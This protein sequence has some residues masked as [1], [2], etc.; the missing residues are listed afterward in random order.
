ML[1]T[2][3]EYFEKYP[4]PRCAACA[5]EFKQWGTSVSTP[6]FT[7]REDDARTLLRWTV[8]EIERLS[9]LVT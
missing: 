9:K 2:I 1:D 6:L 4:E 7:C 3:R 8:R 5:K